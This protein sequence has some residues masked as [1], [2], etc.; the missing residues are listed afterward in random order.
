MRAASITRP[1]LLGWNLEVNHSL[2]VDVDI[3]WLDGLTQ[4]EAKDVRAVCLT[5]SHRWNGGG[6][7]AVSAYIHLC[8]VSSH[9]SFVVMVVQPANGVVSLL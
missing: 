2:P 1:I 4:Q 6:V 7:V 3:T 9:L 5:L 8:V